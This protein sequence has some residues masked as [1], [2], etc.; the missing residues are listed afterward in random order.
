MDFRCQLSKYIT[1]S[2]ASETGGGVTVSSG[3]T[4]MG[5]VAS[6]C[7]VRG[8]LLEPFDLTGILTQRV[9]ESRFPSTIAVSNV[10]AVD[11]EMVKQWA[12]RLAQVGPI[13][14]LGAGPPCQGV[15][16][17]NASRRFA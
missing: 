4:P 13:V 2:D 1:A 10:E 12:Q 14:L 16:G 17:L 5:C 11:F 9:V 6:A 3:V 7:A 15:S 8:D